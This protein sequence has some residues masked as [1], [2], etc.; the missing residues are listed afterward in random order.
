EQRGGQ[1]RILDPAIPSQLPLMPNRARLVLVG[2]LLAAGT[3]VAAAVLAERL[4]TSFRTAEQLRAFS[5]V[6]VLAS[7]PRIVKPEDLPRR[8]AARP[9]PH[10]P[11][12][13]RRTGPARLRG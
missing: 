12:R 11:P 9:S 10:P 6:P 5:K 4:D 7:I 1:F 2:L 3:A 13:S 8:W